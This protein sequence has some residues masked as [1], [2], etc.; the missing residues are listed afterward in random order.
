[1]DGSQRITEKDLERMEQ[2]LMEQ[3]RKRE[4]R[5]F[6]RLMLL[7][8]PEKQPLNPLPPPTPTS[9]LPSTNEGLPVK[10]LGELIDGNN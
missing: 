4:R 8:K 5:E 10:E 1:M 2:L 6:D 7:E 9:C 3:K